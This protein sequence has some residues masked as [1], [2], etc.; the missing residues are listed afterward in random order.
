MDKKEKLRK[1]I[2]E[3]RKLVAKRKKEEARRKYMEAEA[4]EGSDNEENDHVKK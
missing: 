1:M 2:E 4:D 3:R